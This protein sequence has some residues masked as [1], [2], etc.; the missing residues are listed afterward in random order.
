MSYTLHVVS[1]ATGETGE[2]VLRS[3]LAQFPDTDAE[4]ERFGGVRNADQVRETVS[5]ARVQGAVI[6]HTLVSHELRRLMLSE[7]RKQ[8][9]DA[10]DLM[11]PVLDRLTAAFRTRPQE[12]PGL[13]EQL[14]EARTRVIE[15]VDFAFRHDDGQNSADYENAEIILLGVSRTMKTPLCLYLANRGW[16]A[17]NVPVVQGVALPA[18][19]NG[20]EPRRVFGLT[21]RPARLLELRTARAQYL[22]MSSGGYADLPS[23][24]AEVHE[25]ESLFRERGWNTVDVTGKSI[26]EIARQM[27]DLRRLEES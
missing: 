1:D 9:V 2:R 17:A 27:I 26:E 11:G 19:L 18:T 13:F 12:Q 20:V 22:H 3:A 21:M 16:F 23:I 24:R 10:M 4:I 8:D 14:R 5:R 7:C 15:A 6:L 25:A